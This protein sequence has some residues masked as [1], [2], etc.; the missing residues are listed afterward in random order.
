M[1]RLGITAVA[2]LALVAL[3]GCQKEEPTTPALTAACS[4]QPASGSAPLQVHFLLAVSGAEGTYAVEVSYGDGASGSDPDLPHTYLAAGVYTASF[5]V[6]TESQSARCAATVT[7]NGPAPSPS[8]TGNQPPS[9]VFKTTPSASNDTITGPAPFLVGL[10]MCLT[11]D[12][13]NDWLFFSMDF[14]GD[15]KWDSRG[16]FG[17][18]C[19]RG[20]VYAAGTYHATLCVHDIDH[21]RAPLHEDQCHTFTVI[22]TP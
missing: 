3:P 15:G 16:P 7:V 8:P 9:P 14:D 4:A 21:D 13:E 12:P 2:G 19:R 6:S 18:N 20:P 10:N 17:G 11:S 5:A 1:R 22:A